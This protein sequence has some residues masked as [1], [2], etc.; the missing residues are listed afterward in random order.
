MVVNARSD[1]HQCRHAFGRI[2][3]ELERCA[4]AQGRAYQGRAFDTGQVERLADGATIRHE[5]SVEGRLAEP[6]KIDADDLVGVR[7][8]PELRLPHA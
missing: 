5:I 4:P 6:W 2:E 8:R 1:E 7:K 3:R